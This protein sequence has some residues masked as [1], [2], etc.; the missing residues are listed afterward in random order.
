[1]NGT[2]SSN[3]ESNETSKDWRSW[4]PELFLANL[5]HEI[6]TPVM[7][8]KGYTR[9]LAVEKN[10][11]QSAE[12]LDSISSAV[13]RLEQVCQDI[14]EYRRELDQRLDR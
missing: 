8:I 7:I 2:S 3:L 14:V 9:L 11:E 10:T 4:P 12:A 1:M 6:R 13:T 5:L